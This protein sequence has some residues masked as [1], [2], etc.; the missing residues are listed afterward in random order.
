MA[1]LPHTQPTGRSEQ[2]ALVQWLELHKIKYTHV[3][4]GVKIRS[5]KTKRLSRRAR[6]LILIR[7][8]LSQRGTAI[9]LKDVRAAE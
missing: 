6:L 7:R 5:G 1:K 8:Q 9:E 4:N 2:L 3:P